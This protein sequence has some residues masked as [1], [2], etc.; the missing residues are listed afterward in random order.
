MA[1][2]DRIAAWQTLIGVRRAQ[3]AAITLGVTDMASVA[4][5][6]IT[7]QQITDINAALTAANAVTAAIDTANAAVAK[8]D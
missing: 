3:Q 8:P 4:L 6:T 1:Y 2:A 5:N 7:A